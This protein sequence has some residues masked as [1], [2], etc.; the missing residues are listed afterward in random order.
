MS[1]T[2]DF[3]IENGIL[4]K[5]NGPGGEVVIPDGVIEI[6]KIIEAEVTKKSQIPF[7]I[8]QKMNTN[9]VLKLVYTINRPGLILDKNTLGMKIQNGKILWSNRL[10]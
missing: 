9:N 3:I 6:G 1:N 2:Q 7:E 8:R 5:Y 10:C 4:Q